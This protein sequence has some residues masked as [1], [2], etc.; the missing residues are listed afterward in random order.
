MNMYIYIYIH[1][2]CLAFKVVHPCVCLRV[3]K[4]FYRYLC[5]FLNVFGVFLIS[6][7]VGLSW[8]RGCESK[9]RF[10]V[11]HSVCMFWQGCSGPRWCELL[12]RT[13][14]CQIG[15][16]S[17]WCNKLTTCEF[18]R[19]L[20][21]WHV[22]AHYLDPSRNCLHIWCIWSHRIESVEYS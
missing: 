7:D 3:N 22:M 21:V 5:Q 10:D 13:V 2:T 14:T 1:C 17:Y 19:V 16:E 9:S 20:G 6:R 15:W 12:S 11:S 18:R 8:V 4:R